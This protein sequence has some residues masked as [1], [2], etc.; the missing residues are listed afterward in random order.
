MLRDILISARRRWVALSLWMCLCIGVGV[1]YVALTPRE[2]VATT[3]VVLEPRQFTMDAGTSPMPATI[4]P[5]AAES[6]VHVLQSSRN[7]RYVFDRLDLAS[8]PDFLN[9]GF[10]VRIV[11][12]FSKVV[13]W[14]K[15]YLRIRSDTASLSSEELADRKRESAF[16]NFA[17]RVS[18]QRLGQSYAFEI[19]YRAL[20]PQ[21]AAHF[22]NSI[23]AAYIRDQVIYNAA[24]AALRG[25]QYLQNSVLDAKAEEEVVDKAVL[26][27]VIPDYTF[28]LAGARIVSA[29]IEPLTKTYPMT[30][31][32]LG[33][34][35]VIAL[36]T[37]IGAIVLRNEFDRTVRSPE[38]VRRL[39]GIHVF[40]A[41]PKVP[42]PRALSLHEALDEPAAP[43]ARVISSLRALVE[44]SGA[45]SRVVGFVSCNP[46]EGRSSIAANVAYLIA[47]SGQPVTLVDADLRNPALTVALAPTAAPSAGK[48]AMADATGIK[49]TINPTLSFVPATSGIIR[50]AYGPDLLPNSRQTSQSIRGLAAHG[51]VIVDL[52]PLSSSADAIAL[53]QTLTGVVIV[54]ALHKTTV[55]D[56]S[57]AVK[58]MNVVGV[59]LL[60]MVLNEAPRK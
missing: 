14:V 33:L 44:A 29:A 48:L 3:Q 22:A 40:A 41:I 5:G 18:V 16:Q 11:R 1:A 57:G 31:R 17:Q 27:G 25:G 7:L 30:S 56:L 52:P 24:A 23:A 43:F 10:D 21:K 55:D 47:G 20:S 35:A 34:S 8:D 15:G 32:I 58:T 45:N 38:Q 6:Q 49:V 4:D 59:R 51:D 26:T 46:R 28:G 39:T 42:S 9:S 2:F 12:W 54:A 53:S 60:G 50:G 37:G 36:V 19:S 13:D